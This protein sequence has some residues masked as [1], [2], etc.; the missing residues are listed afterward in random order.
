MLTSKVKRTQLT[1]RWT[2]PRGLLTIVL[3]LALAVISEFFMV[4]FFKVAGLTEAFEFKFFTVIISP[5]FHLL[6]LGV[7]LVLVASWVYLTKNL[8]MRKP[9][10]SPAKVSKV[11]RRHPRRRKTRSSSLGKTIKA[12]KNFFSRITGFLPR[13]RNVSVVQQRLTFGKLAFESIVTVL[14]IFLLSLITFYVLIYPNLFTDFAVEVY[15][16]NSALHG[17]V[18]KVIEALQGIAGALA[19]VVSA[20]DSGLRAIAPGF[21]DTFEGF[22]TSR[23]QPLSAGDLLW[24]YVLAQNAAAWISALAAIAYGKYFSR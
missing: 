22:V 12:I 18:L 3:F 9:K 11:H 5:L 21:R 14:T 6:P 7:V 24:R 19:P 15:T 20:I 23:H 1:F 13:Y 17:F 8:A 10:K 2:A 16:T 4:S